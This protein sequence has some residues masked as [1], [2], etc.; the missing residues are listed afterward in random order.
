MRSL[1]QERAKFA[2]ERI[3]EVKQLDGGKQKD[4]RSYVRRLPSII[5][6]SGLSNAL[7]FYK[8]KKGMHLEVYKHLN[9]WF[10]SEACPMAEEVEKEDLLTWLI[11]EADSLQAFRATE[12]T[13]FLLG[14][15][16]KFAESELEEGEE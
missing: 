3:A 5:L 4:Y 14:W 2:W 15:L 6:M 10:H 11:E 16:K 8:S 12:E 1:E 9:K 13:L 7:A